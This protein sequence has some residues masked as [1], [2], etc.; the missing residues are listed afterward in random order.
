MT[1]LSH[2]QSFSEFNQ[3]HACGLDFGTSNSTVA[4]VAHDQVRLIPLEEDHVTIPSAIFF[5]F[6]AADIAY[7]RAAIGHYTDGEPGRF[8]RSLKSILG[9]QL[10]HEQTRVRGRKIRLSEVLTSFLGHLKRATERTIQSEITD[11]VMGRPV[12]FIEDDAAADQKAQDDLEAAARALGFVNIEFQ[13]EPIAAAL[14][15]ESTINDEQLVFVVDIGGGTADFSVVKVSPERARQ[16]NRYQDILANRGIRV[17]GTDFD[18]MISLS[19]VMP[20]FGFGSHTHS[21]KE[22]PKWIFHDL[23]TWSQIPFL[24]SQRI[25]TM[26]RSIRQDA[27][28]P[29][30]VLRLVHAIDRQEGHRIIEAVEH[31]KIDLTET[32]EAQIDLR[33]IEPGMVATLSRREL[34][35]AIAPGV[36]RIVKTITSTIQDARIGASDVNAVFLTGG[37]S[38]IPIIRTSIGSIFQSARIVDGDMF[39]SVGKGLGLDASRKFR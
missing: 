2:S 29:D 11:A 38:M 26:L 8:M 34:E 31:A 23:S 9:H 27:A 15:Y 5:S 12:Q 18:R 28:R 25:K 16:S 30:L 35:N 1:A 36:E 7:G 22:L 4:V 21:G 6:V 24:Y 14:D 19:R 17:G 32:S 3:A 20:L 33:R 37:S 13:F 10:F 39:G